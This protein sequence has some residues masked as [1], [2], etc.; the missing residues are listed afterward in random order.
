MS[1]GRPDAGPLGFRGGVLTVGGLGLLR[2]APGTWGSLPP[3]AVA[4][5][6]LATGGGRLEIAIAMVLLVAAG[7]IACVRFGGWAERRWRR[8]DPSAVVADEVAGMAV[9]LLA[10][11]WRPGGGDGRGLW[12]ADLQLAVAGFVLFRLFDILKPPP[13]RRLER[14]PGGWGV[15]LDDLAAGA[16]AGGVLLGWVWLAPLGWR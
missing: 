16:L 9:T 10:V 1:D 14:C 12:E 7:S 4:T 6:L 13:I 2:P 11:P 5:L 8:R 15:L 3:L